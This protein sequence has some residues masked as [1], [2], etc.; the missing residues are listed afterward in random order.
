M[1]QKKFW[2]AFIVVFI[3]YEIT[4]FIVHGLILGSTY[5]NE[6]ITPLF[7]PQAILDSTM[8]LRL[9]TELVWSF[10][11][12]FIFV[13]GYENKGIME[14]V[15]F[16]IYVGLFYSFVWAYQSYWMY[17][18]PYSLALQWFIFGLIQCIILGILAAMI[19]KPKPAES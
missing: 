7:R 2:I 9:F 4:N 17:P 8:W 3:V 16:G 11:F 15:K 19:Y 6:E 10:F 13:K 14:G 12:T 1:N 18:M 5:M